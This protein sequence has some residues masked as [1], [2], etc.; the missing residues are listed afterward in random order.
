M[1]L[2]DHVILVMVREPKTVIVSFILGN[3][4]QL[5]SSEIYIIFLTL[6]S[7]NKPVS[8]PKG[9]GGIAQ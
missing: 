4:K 8:S 2:S 5:G 7:L 3:F 1:G 6:A 9:S